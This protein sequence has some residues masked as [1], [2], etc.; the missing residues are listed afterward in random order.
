M[1]SNKIF[2]LCLINN[3]QSQTEVGF[4]AYP[5]NL[6]VGEHCEWLVWKCLL[7]KLRNLF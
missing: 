4:V 6:Y 3:Y 2:Y 7:E 5:N 1:L